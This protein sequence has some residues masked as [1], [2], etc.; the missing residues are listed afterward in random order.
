MA[1]LISSLITLALLLMLFVGVNA[2]G[3]DKD[4]NFENDKKTE[5]ELDPC[6][7]LTFPDCFPHFTWF[8]SSAS[9]AHVLLEKKNTANQRKWS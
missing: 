2:G 9:F 4:Q 8:E 1:K 5:V 6:S 3:G 7:V